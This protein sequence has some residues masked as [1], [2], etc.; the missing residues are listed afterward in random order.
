MKRT[1][2]LAAALLLGLTGPAWAQSRDDCT[3]RDTRERA[4]DLAQEIHD[5]TGGDPQKAQQIHE[6][7]KNLEVQR[8]EDTL[9]RTE[10]GLQDECAR[11]EQRMDEVEEAT[12]RAE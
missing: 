6:E 9:A 7:L 3:P 2:T 11:Y 5:A 1:I 10:Q 12:D 4:G 8:R